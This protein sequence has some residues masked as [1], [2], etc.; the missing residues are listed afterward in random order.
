MVS[1]KSCYY[2]GKPIIRDNR[3]SKKQLQGVKF[4]NRICKSKNQSKGGRIS[5]S[6]LV[7]GRIVSRAISQVKHG[8][9]TCSKS[10]KVAYMKLIF[11]GENN[12][13]YGKHHSDET[14]RLIRAKVFLV[15]KPSRR[16]SNNHFWKGG[17]SQMNHRMRNNI[18]DQPDYKRFRLLVLSRDRVCQHCGSE[19]E[20]QVHHLK[21]FELYPSLRMDVNNAIVLC[22]TCHKKTDSYG[23]KKRGIKWYE[24]LRKLAKTVV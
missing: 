2:C 16:G 22:K 8:G 20:L 14:K 4:C 24:R 21:E 9:K 15:P 13:F 3:Y 1:E 23:R 19:T 11:L 12:P 10:C 5:F 6:C 18:M 17:V 7:C